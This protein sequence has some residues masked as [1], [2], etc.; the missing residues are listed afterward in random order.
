MIQEYNRAKRITKSE[1][2]ANL[3]LLLANP[4]IPKT[5]SNKEI[6]EKAGMSEKHFYSLMRNPDFLQKIQQFCGLTALRYAPGI[7]TAFAERG[8]RGAFQQGRTVLEM[9]GVVKQDAPIIQQVIAVLNK[10]GMT[11]EDIDRKIAEYFMNLP[12]NEPKQEIV[13]VE[14]KEGNK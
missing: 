8:L 6:A 5:L 2:Q 3:L 9:A 12:N 14:S 7:T 1:K 11:E 4:E 13:A 10:G